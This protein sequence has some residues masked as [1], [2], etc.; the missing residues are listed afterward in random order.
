MEILLWYIFTFCYFLLL[1]S[2]KKLPIAENGEN[3]I[4]A[5]LRI[6]RSKIYIRPQGTLSNN[7]S[8]ISYCTKFITS[9]KNPFHL[10]K[11]LTYNKFSLLL[12]P[13]FH[14]L[15]HIFPR[16]RADIKLFK[17]AIRRPT[18]RTHGVWWHIGGHIVRCRQITDWKSLSM[19]RHFVKQIKGCSQR[20]TKFN[21]IDFL[22]KL[23]ERN[24]K[25]KLQKEK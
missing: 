25:K 4:S 12:D 14:E 11:I 24:T 3:L 9:P 16:S 20:P 19:L 15:L 17:M 13:S 18:G 8:V 1:C 22:S 21:T 6:S 7:I 5:K 23:Q 2:K 10:Q